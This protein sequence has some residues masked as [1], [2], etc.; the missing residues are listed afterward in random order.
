MKHPTISCHYVRALM[1]SVRRRDVDPL[2][3]LKIAGIPEHIAY[4][5]NTRIPSEQLVTLVRSTWHALNDE[6]MGLTRTPLAM[7]AFKYA[8]LLMAS[9]PT[10]RQA[11]H[12]GIEFYN[13]VN[14]G[15]TLTLV[16][17][18]ADV[19]IEAKLS[20]PELDP[21]HLLTEFL[22]VVWHRLPCWLIG[23]TIVLKHAGFSF[24]RPAHEAE[25]QHF[26]S[27]P[28]QF[29]QDRLSLR[30]SQ[31]YLDQPVVRNQQD[32]EVFVEQSPLGLVGR[33]THDD[34]YGTKIRLHIEAYEAQGFP[35]F[36]EIA[37]HFHMTPKNLRQKL[38]EEGGTYQTIKDVIRRDSAIHYLTQQR[39]SVTDIAVKVGFSETGAFIR[40]F[41]GWTGITPGAYFNQAQAN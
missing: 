2:P 22:A 4:D 9:A 27:C 29:N 5:R 25:Y 31:H 38:K 34:S 36:D 35:S 21:D 19:V 18:G 41:K 30:F 11:L 32:A 12:R 3:L 16:E 6:N 7:D 13:Y 8:T 15:Y 33:P 28:R 39:C 37:E 10:L 17:Q 14:K 1:E 20:Q 23:Q 24:P 40:A 26:V